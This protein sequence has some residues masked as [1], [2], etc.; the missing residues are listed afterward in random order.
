M[1]RNEILNQF[2]LEQEQ[3]LEAQNKLNNLQTE[4]ANQGTV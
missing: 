2:Q 1:E 3:R 4:L